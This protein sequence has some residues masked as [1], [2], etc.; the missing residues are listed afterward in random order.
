MIN[1][2]GIKKIIRIS[3]ISI[4]TLILISYAY[5][6]SHNFINGPKIIVI[7]PISGSSITTSSMTLKGTA[8]RIKDISLNGRPIL[9]D[10]KG[11]FNEVLVLSPGYNV[12]LLSAH[13]KFGRT[14]EYK[15]E[16][17]YQR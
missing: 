15:I 13:D 12:S 14:T 9:I 2:N 1:R 8:L 6:T 5:F 3:I 4:I 16:L 7:E 17:V 10:E 11:N